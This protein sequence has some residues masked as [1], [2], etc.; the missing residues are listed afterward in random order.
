M[1][2]ND[3]RD[4]GRVFLTETYTN[5]SSNLKSLYVAAKQLQQTQHKLM[6]E[7]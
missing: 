6:N 2:C 4:G 3:I 5:Y 1:Q 7:K